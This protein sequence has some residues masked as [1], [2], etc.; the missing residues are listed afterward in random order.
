MVLSRYLYCNLKVFIW[1]LHRTY[2]LPRAK[3]HQGLGLRLACQ[4]IVFLRIILAIWKSI[5]TIKVISPTYFSKKKN[6]PRLSITKPLG[7][8][9]PIPSSWHLAVSVENR[10]PITEKS[11][12]IW[13]LHL[14]SIPLHSSN[15]KNVRQPFGADIHFWFRTRKH[16]SKS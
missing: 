9:V 5:D 10:L 16:S 4:Q 14:F 7:H 12:F 15:F 8:I 6:L 2:F 13:N 11:W 3:G 1:Y